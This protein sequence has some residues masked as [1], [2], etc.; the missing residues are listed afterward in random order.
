MGA[1]AVESLYENVVSMA[2]RKPE[3]WW[4][5]H[6]VHLERLQHLDLKPVLVF[7]N[8]R[9]GGQQ[10]SKVLRDTWHLD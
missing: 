2:V 1:K 10:G 9:S 3:A 4:N 7:V 8:T 5:A 6:Q